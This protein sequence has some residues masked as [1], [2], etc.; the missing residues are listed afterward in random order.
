[1]RNKIITSCLVGVGMLALTGMSFA[2]TTPAKP[3]IGSDSKAKPAKPET[4]MDSKASEKKATGDVTSVDAKAGKLAV[5][6]ADQDLSLNV[7]ASAA[8]KSLESIKVG[9]KVNVSYRDQGGILTASS[10]SK[11]SATPGPGASR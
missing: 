9:D 2:Q 4:G 8:K 10:V 1:M 5:K 7:D 6:T 11:S 3:D